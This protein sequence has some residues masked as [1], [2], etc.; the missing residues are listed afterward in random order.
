M[1]V[2][3]MYA[4]FDQ[5]GTGTQ[6]ADLKKTVPVDCLT[7]EFQKTKKEDSLKKPWVPHNVRMKAIKEI[8]LKLAKKSSIWQTFSDWIE[9]MAL[10]ISCFYDPSH[11]EERTEMLNRFRD[12]YSDDE[13]KAFLEAFNELCEVIDDNLADG[14]FT[15]VL[16]SLYMDMGL[17]SQPNGQYFSPDSIC[18]MMGSI[19][20]GS[21]DIS[22]KGH[23]TICEPAAGSG[24]TLLGAFD[25]AAKQGINHKT[26]IAAFAVD[27]DIRCVHM[28]Y[29]QLSL[30]GVPAVVQHGDS[31]SLETWHRWYTPVYVIDDWVWRERL[32]FVEGRNYEDER[33]K[34]ILQPMYRFMVYGIPNLK[35]ENKQEEVVSSAL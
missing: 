28:C 29:I 12:K 19:S 11:Y 8:L 21:A 3:E 26:Q 4:L 10:L 9:I 20:M 22:E 34:C 7:P 2:E 15:D 5:I 23:I 32:T 6:F 16:G 17:S 1:D 18:K 27:T 25:A 35:N 14:Y 31:L 13:T 24:A 30:Y 33:L